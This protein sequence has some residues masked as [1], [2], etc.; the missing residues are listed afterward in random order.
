MSCKIKKISIHFSIHATESHE[1]NLQ[2]LNSLIP[3]S[4]IENASKFH[5]TLEGGYG[6]PIEYFEISINNQRDI[7]SVLSNLS[8]S[9]TQKE[10]HQLWLEF[11]ERFDQKSKEFFFRVDKSYALDNKIKLAETSYSFKIAIK[12][13]SFSKH[14]NFEQILVD[15]DILRPHS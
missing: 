11:D 10:K 4:V 5:Y 12:I 3:E 1:K 9:L 7:K 6:N 15:F 2:A 8:K 13:V 14:D